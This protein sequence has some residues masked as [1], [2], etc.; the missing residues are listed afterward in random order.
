MES[1]WRSKGTTGY[2]NVPNRQK[3]VF[4][5]QKMTNGRIDSRTWGGGGKGLKHGRS[6]I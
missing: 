1:Q 6:D 3:I 5:R 4:H 2:A